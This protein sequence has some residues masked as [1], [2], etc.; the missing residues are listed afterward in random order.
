MSGWN[1]DCSRDCA[2]SLLTLSKTRRSA[3]KAKHRNRLIVSLVLAAT[4]FLS[5]GLVKA[6]E[7]DNREDRRARREERKWENRGQ[8][9]NRRNDDAQQRRQAEEQRRNSD[10]Q[11]QDQRRQADE[12]QRQAERQ[13]Q[14]QQ[15]I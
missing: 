5:A 7:S 12:Q 10:R 14:E 8:N 4:T 13:R 2:I 15:Q 1:A 11:A 3:M 6:Q 9:E